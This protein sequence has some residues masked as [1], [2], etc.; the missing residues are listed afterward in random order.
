VSFADSAQ[1]TINAG[2][3]L[4]DAA[5]YDPCNGI[6]KSVTVVHEHSAAVELDNGIGAR[7]P[8]NLVYVRKSEVTQPVVGD[9]VTVDGSTYTVDGYEPVNQWEWQ[10]Y[11]RA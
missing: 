11:V 6:P 4:G 10:L 2:Y 7:V 5:T 1:R 3:G 8:G 9:K